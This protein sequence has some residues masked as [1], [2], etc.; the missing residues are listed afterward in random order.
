MC[1]ILAGFWMLALLDALTIESWLAA[2]G[3]LLLFLLLMAC[4]LGLPLPED[5]PLIAAGALIAAGKLEWWHVAVAGWG[6][7]MCGDLILYHLGRRFGHH[8]SR[9]PVVG[10]H[11]TERRMERVEAWFRRYGIWA[12]ALGRM[13]A[14]V[15]AVMVV[16]AGTI[17]FSRVKFVL[18]DGV[19]AVASGGVF[20]LLG[21]WLGQNLPEL[22]RR[23]EHGKLVLFGGL[24]GVAAVAGVWWWRRGRRV[25]GLHA[26]RQGSPAGRA[27][28]VD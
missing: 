5:I 15:R 4:G 11:L 7:I 18:A 14:G 22:L 2:G 25:A 3:S 16:T 27:D 10:R 21:Y 20:V 12:V 1:L 6:G 8:V 24:A 19:A 23:V 26:S 17:R 13:V 28:S 9:L